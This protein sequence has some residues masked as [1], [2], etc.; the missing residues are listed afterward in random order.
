MKTKVLL[1]LIALSISKFSFG[2]V[3]LDNTH[4]VAKCVK[5]TNME[6]YPDVAF[7]GFSLLMGQMRQ[8]TELSSTV[9]LDK[10]YK[11]NDFTVYA[12][13]KSY[14]NGKDISKI[15]F[16]KESNALP[17]NIAINPY[18][19][20]VNDS[21]PLSGIEE[22][23]KVV[24]FS[25]KNVILFKWKQVT[26]YNNGK[27]DLIESFT[28]D[29]EAQPLY[30][31]IIVGINASEKSSVIEVFPN[32]AHK[33]IHLRINDS[34]KGTVSVDLVDTAGKVMKTISF[35]KSE[36]LLNYDIPVSD[37]SKAAYSVIIHLGKKVES[38]KIVIK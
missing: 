34:Y 5:I 19:G 26:K 1:I 23:Y 13:N 15:D 30:Q 9:C 35:S 37:M 8:V 12:V 11:F 3:I 36:T 18:M 32:P 24:G 33:M 16:R 20:F 25:D 28:Y 14:L 4:Y 31:R 6:D 10:G 27:P 29:P 2:D 22:Y 38:R 7:I 17:S 21:I